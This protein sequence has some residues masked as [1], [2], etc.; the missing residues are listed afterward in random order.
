MKKTVLTFMV[1]ILGA[2]AQ[3]QLT[4][5]ADGNSVRQE[6]TERIGLTNVSIN[7]GRPAVRGRDG[8]IWGGLVYEG[9]K[10]LGFGTAKESP[11]R[12]G[13]NECT[14]MEF[15]T[16]VVIEGKRLPAGKYAFFIAY[17]PASSTL[18][19]SSGT[20]GWGSFFY[21]PAEDV[22]RVDVAPVKLPTTRERLT[23]QFS[24]ET[25]SSAVISLEWEKLAIPFKVSTRLHDL[26]MA[27]FKRELKGEKGFD[28]HAYATVAGY[29][30]ETNTDLP[31]ALAYADRAALTMPVFNVL[32]TKAGILREMGKTQEADNTMKQAMVVA[33]ERE[34]H[35]YGRGLLR[36][37]KKDEAFDA[38][39]QNYKNH[40]DTYTTT[41]GM[42]RGCSAT[43]KLKDA[44]KYANK[45][46][47]LA[48]DDLNKQSV[49]QA[50]ATLKAGKKLNET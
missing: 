43:G 29:M 40:P 10:Y 15:S 5:P 1:A 24:D 42:M 35:Y 17:G 39:R 25:D 19:F 45:A 2:N 26:Q 12:A 36:A 30:L 34:L 16:D 33:S 28:P 47:S 49:E 21:D 7:Y 22:L 31:Q 37:G 23:Y 14:T 32:Q 50:I 8:K 4:T 48:P 20:A 13:A 3:A 18:I 44:L 27:S 6:I 9:F 41:V 11:W 38:F 46:L